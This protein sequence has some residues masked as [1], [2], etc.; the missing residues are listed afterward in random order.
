MTRHSML[1]P[2]LFLDAATCAAMGLLL[3]LGAD[4][5]AAVTALPVALLREAG[6]LL[7]PFAAFVLWTARHGGGWPVRTVVAI[8]FAWVAASLALIASPWTGNALGVAFVAAQA[9][10][11]ALLAALQWRGLARAAAA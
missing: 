6:I 8:N 7:L 4:L 11:V 3:A 2:I 9:A 1:R 10:C 5:V